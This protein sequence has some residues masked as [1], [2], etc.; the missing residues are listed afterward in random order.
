MFDLDARLAADT[1][2]VGDLPLCRV[3]LMND[4]QF[5]WVILV[6]RREDARELFE[7]SEQDQL[8]FM[9]ESSQV[10]QTLNKLFEPDKLNVAALGNVVAQLHIH[11][12]AR[13]QNDIAWPAPVWGRQPAVTYSDAQ[14]TQRIYDLQQCLFTKENR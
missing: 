1:F 9:Q 2:L 7:L 4:Q 6:P 12:V 8:A 14:K 13:F 3:L 5:P 10:C 11:H